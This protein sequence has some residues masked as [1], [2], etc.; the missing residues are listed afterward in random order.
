MTQIENNTSLPED[1]ISPKDVA[2]KIKQSFASVKKNWKLI[3]ICFVLGT[4][5]GWVYDKYNYTPTR[6]LGFLAFNLETGQSGS[7]MGGLSDLASAFGLGSGGSTSS[8]GLFVGENFLQLVKST[9]M[10]EKALM[11]EV[12]IKGKK[13]LL[14][15]YYIEKSGILDEEWEKVEKFRKIRFTT[16]PREQY[17]MDENIAMMGI[18]K[19]INEETSFDRKSP[20]SSFLILK[21]NTQDEML[22]KVWLETLL[23][24][25]EEFYKYT[26]TKK[27]VEILKMAQR[28]A[29]SLYNAL[30]RTENRLAQFTDQNQ[31]VIAQQAQVTTNRLNRNTGILNTMY[32]DAVRNVESIRISLI[33]ETPFITIIEPPVLPLLAEAYEEGKSIKAGALIGIVLALAIIFL[34]KTVIDIINS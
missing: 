26:N 5:L 8:S 12:T 33:K 28:R 10:L 31:Q 4:G 6:Y 18:V 11:K 17:S 14:V 30:T 32:F 24:T 20:K 21:S 27:T 19:K 23:S 2:R 3:V 15:N 7:D 16:K 9:P 34:R 25:V 29:D 22:S 13:T 1:Q